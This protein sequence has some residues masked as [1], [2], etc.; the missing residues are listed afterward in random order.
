MLRASLLSASPELCIRSDATNTPTTQIPGHRS[1]PNTSSLKSRLP[2]VIIV[3]R[4]PLLEPIEP[5]LMPEYNVVHNHCFR[6][7]K[8]S[9]PG[10]PLLMQSYEYGPLDLGSAIG[11]Q[12]NTTHRRIRAP[13]RKVT[14]LESLPSL[15]SEVAAEIGRRVQIQEQAGVLAEIREAKERESER[16][17]RASRPARM[18][19]LSYVAPTFSSYSAEDLEAGHLSEPPPTP[20]IRPVRAQLRKMPDQQAGHH[21]GD[22]LKQGHV[23]WAPKPAPQRRRDSTTLNKKGH[24]GIQTKPRNESK[25]P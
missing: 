16:Q 21:A 25:E 24:P 3:G 20:L 8:N 6:T 11:F 5:A 23:R 10:E 22:I 18:R 4:S 13:P 17:R 12:A 7:P 15:S 19:L 14:N 2:S 9:E 1:A